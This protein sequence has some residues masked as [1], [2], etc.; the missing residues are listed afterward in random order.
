MDLK[1]IIDTI[2]NAIATEMSANVELVE[3]SLL[4]DKLTDRSEPA[5][6]EST[7][8]ALDVRPL[9]LYDP[10]KRLSVTYAVLRFLWHIFLALLCVVYGV[11]SLLAWA[12][13]GR[14]HSRVTSIR[15]NTVFFV[16]VVISYATIM[17]M[18]IAFFMFN[19]L[20]YTNENN[21][22][23]RGAVTVS[24]SCNREHAI[25]LLSSSS[26]WANTG[27]QVVEGDEIEVTSSGAFHGDIGQ[28][29]SCAR[30]NQRPKYIFNRGLEEREHQRND[31]LLCPDAPF[32]ALLC[33]IRYSSETEY[34]KDSA[35]DSAKDSSNGRCIIVPPGKRP[36]KAPKGGELFFCVNDIYPAKDSDLK[37]YW[38]GDN[39][40][41]LLLNISIT[42]SKVDNPGILNTSLFARIY[43]WLETS[44]YEGTLWKKIGM[45]AGIVILWL[46]ADWFVS[47]RIRKY[48]EKHQ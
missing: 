35:K 37:E 22:N 40:G 3:R 44:A 47:R 11:V 8:K 42:R 45:A 24:R 15:L 17:V 13:T 48:K 1:S 2:R 9:W 29:D 43:R 12:V 5:P 36:F 46:F 26:F 18:M 27:I 19:V 39:V 33:D 4:A 23:I 31:S 25:Y 14:K 34:R 6:S 28:L 38:Y 41:E 7:V 30:R 10:S 32:G 21:V 16:A 20:F